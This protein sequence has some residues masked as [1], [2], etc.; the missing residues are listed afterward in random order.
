MDFAVIELF[1][2]GGEFVAVGSCPQQCWGLGTFFGRS[3]QI[4]LGFEG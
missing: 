4:D 3:Y 1:A 2:V